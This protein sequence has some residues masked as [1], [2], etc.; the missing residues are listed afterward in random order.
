MEASTEALYTRVRRPWTRTEKNWFQALGLVVGSTLLAALVLAAEKQWGHAE[1]ADRL[2][3]NPVETAMRVFALP[4]FVIAILFMTTSRAMRA[5]RSWAWFAGYTALG[6]ALCWLFAR[7]GGRSAA[8]PNALF[9]TYFLVH[10]FRDQVFFYRVNGDAPMGPD[11]DGER[12]LLLMI[13]VIGLLT[14]G[15][16]FLTGAAFRIGGAR[17]YT[18]AIFGGLPLEARWVLGALVI[19]GLIGLVHIWR[20]RV[21]ASEPEGFLAFVRR[22]RPM[23]VVFGGILAVLVLDILITGRAYAIV[24]LHVA[25]WFVFVS[26]GYDLRPAPDPMPKP[27]SWSWLRA[28]GPGFRFLHNGLVLLVLGLA[29]WWAYGFDNDPSR[30]GLWTLLSKDAFPYWTIMHVTMSWTPK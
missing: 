11:A 30:R 18:D 4:H 1:R 13:P 5:A 7:A 20:R 28:T 6:V 22:N 26:R 17:R 23:F 8:L 21:E 9:L 24:T 15:G 25:T 29:V 12:R 2:V 10:E 27:L 16:V 3:Y 19:A 14:I